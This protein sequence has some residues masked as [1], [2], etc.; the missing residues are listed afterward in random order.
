MTNVKAINQPYIFLLEVANNMPIAA[1]T[2]NSI[3][4]P[5]P[6]YKDKAVLFRFN[7]APM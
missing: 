4:R 1:T 6:A 2:N 7:P 3:A 5:L